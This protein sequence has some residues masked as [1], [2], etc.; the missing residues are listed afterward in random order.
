MNEVIVIASGKGGVGKTVFAANMGAVLA[1]RDA[2]VLLLDM[3]MGL[4]N[5]D[6]CLGMESR[7]VYDV[8]D[9]LFGV[10]RLKQALIRDRRF[11][12]LYFMSAAQGKESA[13][14]DAGQVQS[15]YAKLREMF[16]YIIVDAPTGIGHGLELAAAGADRA[17][18]IAIPEYASLRDADM[19]DRI[20]T[21]YGIENRKY[22]V[23]KVKAELF[24]QGS[25]PSLEEM[26]EVL[27]M[28]MAGVIQYDENIH[29]AANNGV[30]IVYKQ[31]TY[32]SDNFNHIVDRILK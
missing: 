24:G 31:G 26:S 25:F 28:E 12:E 2:K 30:P 13:K 10:C 6:L 8:S 7:V 17:V 5:L 16:D 32:V 29:I 1:Q 23:N 21:D 19:V 11:T 27:R 22:V 15:L 20:L 14:L 4:R 18:I 3:N 9:V